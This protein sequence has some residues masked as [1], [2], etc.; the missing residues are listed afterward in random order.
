MLTDA[1]QHL[2]PSRDTW[3]AVSM[4]NAGIL[5]RYRANLVSFVANPMLKEKN[6]GFLAVHLDSPM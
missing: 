6:F 3:A 5:V 1:T 2:Q 4:Q